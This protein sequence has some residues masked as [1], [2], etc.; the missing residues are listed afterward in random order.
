MIDINIVGDFCVENLDGLSFGE[1]LQKQLQSAKIN[2]VNFEGPIFSEK[3]VA[4]KKSGP[5]LYQSPNCPSRLID[6]GFNV[7]S[8]ANNHIMDYGEY[9]AEETKNCFNNYLAI[10]YGDF[11]QAYKLGIYES[12][13]K[14]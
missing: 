7:F 2:V 6:E 11:R 13:G 5:N 12:E 9:C 1:K 3:G 10:G 14:N 8:L 4:I